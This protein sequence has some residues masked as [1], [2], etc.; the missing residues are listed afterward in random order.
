ME[1]YDDL[2]YRSKSVVVG[3]AQ[4]VSPHSVVFDSEVVL[5]AGFQIVYFELAGKWFTVGKIRDLHEKHTGY[6]CD[7]ATPPRFLDDSVEQTDLFLDLWVS[8]DLRYKVLDEEEFEDAYKKGWI[9]QRLY[10]KAKNELKK[11][12]STVEA[13]DFPPRLVKSLEARLHL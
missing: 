13:D 5:A 9:T 1:M 11:L 12:V 8:S 4:I 10:Q 3:R 2:V 7:I 6:Y